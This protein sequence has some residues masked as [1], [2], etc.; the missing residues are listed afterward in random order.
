MQFTQLGDAVHAARYLFA[1]G[2]P[3]LIERHLGVFQRVVQQ[4]GLETNHIHLHVGQDQ[5]D[6]QRMDHIRLARI[7]NLVFMSFRSQ[8]VSLFKLRKVVLGTEQ[9]HLLLELGVQLLD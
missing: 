7:A 2:L 1:E 5:R 4:T 6:I 9:T 8:P 3:D